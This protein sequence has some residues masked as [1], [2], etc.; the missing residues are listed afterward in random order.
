LTSLIAKTDLKI[1]VQQKASRRE[2][3]SC[4]RQA[5]AQAAHERR[6]EWAGIGALGVIGAV[7]LVVA[8]AAHSAE[9]RKSAMSVLYLLVGGVIGYVT[10]RASRPN[11][12]P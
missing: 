10:G 2:L 3:E 9:D 1:E 5:E 8:V 11:P 4:L 7:C 6:K 12:G